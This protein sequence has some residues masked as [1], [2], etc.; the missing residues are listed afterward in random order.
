MGNFYSYEHVINKREFVRL[1]GIDKVCRAMDE[2]L[3]LDDDDD[4]S[5]N[6]GTYKHESRDATL[7]V[8]RHG[9]ERSSFAHCVVIYLILCSMIN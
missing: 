7:E 2:I 9:I 1:G 6:D 8:A 4:D 3:K 5:M